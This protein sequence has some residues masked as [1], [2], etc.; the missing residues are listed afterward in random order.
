MFSSTHLARS[1][2]DVRLPYDV[3]VRTLPFPSSPPRRSSVER[4][5]PEPAAVDI[6]NLVVLREPLV[7]ER[8]VGGEQLEDAAILAQLALEE[9][10]GLAG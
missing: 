7:E 1:T 4:H 9:E 10:L 2:G 8:V 5:A 6:R 3:T